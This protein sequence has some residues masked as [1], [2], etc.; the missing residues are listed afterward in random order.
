MQ[1][2]FYHQSIAAI[3]FK[4]QLSSKYN[5][6]MIYENSCFVKKKIVIK[7]IEHMMKYGSWKY[8]YVQIYPQLFSCNINSDYEIDTIISKPRCR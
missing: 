3:S 8:Q 1:H 5:L 6:T 2:F 7:S 4:L